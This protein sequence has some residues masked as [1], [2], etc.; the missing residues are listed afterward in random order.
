MHLCPRPVHP[1]EVHPGAHGREKLAEQYFRNFPKERYRT[2]V[3][4]W[5]ELQSNNIEFTMS[6]LREPIERDR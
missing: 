1:R 4:S 6:R 5:R 3:K 2:Q